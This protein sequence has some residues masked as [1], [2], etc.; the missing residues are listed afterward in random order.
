MITQDGQEPAGDY[1]PI[2]QILDLS[3]AKHFGTATSAK[4][5]PNI[6]KQGQR[7]T[8]VAH[9]PFS[10]FSNCIRSIK[11]EIELVR[12]E[13]KIQCIGVTSLLGGEGTSTLASNLAQAF[14]ASGRSTLLMDCDV[15]KRAITREFAG[16]AKCGLIEAISGKVN[17]AD[18]VVRDKFLGFSLLPIFVR[19]P[20][21]AF[22]DILGSAAMC[23]VLQEMRH[24]YE[25]ML[26]DLQPLASVPDA[27]AIS[28]F[29]DGFI[30]VVEYGRTPIDTLADRLHS[31]DGSPAKVI[32]IVGNKW[33][34]E[35]Q[36]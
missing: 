24:S 32:G 35:Q 17:F 36:K 26:I 18:A 23:K 27:H 5:R 3:V 28:P 11:T 9:S 20:V 8:W 1:P 21:S 29:L 16:A 34:N 25:V 13:S 12:L 15:R 6:S 14:A 22:C 4:H 30:I 10:S 33:I 19:T 31:L 2:P 7:M